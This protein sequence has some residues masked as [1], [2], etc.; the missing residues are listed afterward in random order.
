MRV[1][2]ESPRGFFSYV[3]L[4][5]KGKIEK[6]IEGTINSC[7]YKDLEHDICISDNRDSNCYVN[8]DWKFCDDTLYVDCRTG[9]VTRG[10]AYIE[11]VLLE[12]IVPLFRD[13]S[14]MLDYTC[15]K[16]L[17]TKKPCKEI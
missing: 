17:Y 15:L 5:R 14:L 16:N 1:F 9:E 2:I 8:Q 11:G 7:I 13:T 10:K 4:L 6:I 12:C 3:T